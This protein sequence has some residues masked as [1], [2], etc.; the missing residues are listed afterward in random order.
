MPTLV[1]KIPAL[2][3]QELKRRSHKDI[4]ADRLYHRHPPRPQ[5]LKQRIHPQPFGIFFRIAG[6]AR[7]SLGQPGIMQQ[8]HGR[9]D[10]PRSHGSSRRRL[11]V[12]QILKRIARICTLPSFKD[13]VSTA[14]D[15]LIE[16]KAILEAN[17]KTD[18]LRFIVLLKDLAEV[19]NRWGDLVD[20][21]TISELII[22]KIA[23]YINVMKDSV[24]ESEETE[25]RL[26]IMYDSFQSVVQKSIV[27]HHSFA[28]SKKVT[29]CVWHVFKKDIARDL[30]EFLQGLKES[31]SKVFSYIIQG[32]T[33]SIAMLLDLEECS[34]FL[35]LV[36]KLDFGNKNIPERDT[37]ESFEFS[38]RWIFHLAAETKTDIY[39]LYRSVIQR[40]INSRRDIGGV[41]E[42][43]AFE[44]SPQIDSMPD[45]PVRDL[46][47]ELRHFTICCRPSVFIKIMSMRNKV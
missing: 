45:K 16:A 12:T 10:R 29:D 26:L 40:T 35:I 34:L 32:Y 44:K 5:P 28:F 30:D 23:N 41:L 15:S 17:R 43:I 6:S 18:S 25:N 7:A 21:F 1:E 4:P 19:N 14:K 33:L 46:M 22:Q 24:D 20:Y 27:H 13:H 8:S 2:Y 9:R 11:S 3:L 31:R 37:D 39:E 38:T 36:D 42:S 47:S